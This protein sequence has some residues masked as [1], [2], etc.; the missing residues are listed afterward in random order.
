TSIP[1]FIINQHRVDEK[2][3]MEAY[4]SRV[5]M[6]DEALDQ[7]LV[8]AKAAQAD[9]VHMPGFTYD[10]S[11]GEIRR[12]TTGAPFTA[13]RDAALFADATTKIKAL[14]DAGK[15]TAEE[16]RASE[17]QVSTVMTEQMKPAYDRVA[18]FLAEDKPD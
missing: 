9:G 6:I 5:G 18:A 10:Q 15:P 4:I 16:A 13:G 11:L 7:L 17:T 14:Q 2:S 12:V 3:D 1:N 8:R